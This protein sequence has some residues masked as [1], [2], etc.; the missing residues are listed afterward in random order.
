MPYLRWA[1]PMTPTIR[2]LTGREGRSKK[3]P[4]TV[5]M[6]TSTMAPSG[7]NRRGLAISKENGKRLR[8]LASVRP[9]E[10]SA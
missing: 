7:R 1:R 10:R 4:W 8:G 2:S 3:R 6:V 5:R 9:D